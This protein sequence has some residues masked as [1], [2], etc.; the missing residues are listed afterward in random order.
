MNNRGNAYSMSTDRTS[1]LKKAVLSAPREISTLRAMVYTEIMSGKWNMPRL[2]SRARA[3]SLLMQNMPAVIYDGE[4]LVGGITEKRRGA[5]LAPETNT[6]GLSM[7]GIMNKPVKKILKTIT[8]NLVPLINRFSKKAGMALTNAGMLFDITFDNP[9][10]RGS[11]VFVVGK[12]EAADIKNTVLPYWKN[13]TAIK[14]FRASLGTEAKTE[15]NS[16]LYSAEHAF[17]GG[18]FLFHP[19]IER[20]AER[21]L[22]SV[23]HEAEEHYNRTGNPFYTS[24][25]VSCQGVIDRAEKYALQAEALAGKSI[26]EE[27]RQELLVIAEICRRVPA[28]PPVTFREGL[29]SLWFI[30]TAVANDDCGHEVPFGRWDQMLYPLYEKDISE[31]ILTREGALE[32]IECFILKTNEIEFLLHNGASFFED[33]NTGRLTLTIGG[34]DRDGKDATNEVSH[35]FIE[36]LSNARM[37]Q[38]NPAVRLHRDSPEKFV[39]LVTQMMAS[40]ANTVQIFNDETVIAGFTGNGYPPTD[41]RDY[42][43]TGCVQQMPFAAYG[44]ACAAHLVLPRTLEEFLGK[45]GDYKTYEEFYSA[46]TLYLSGII[47]NLTGV[48][49]AADRIHEEFLPNPF[50]SAIVDGPMQKGIDVK[51]GG[52]T[53][54]LTG[55]SLLGLGTVADSLMVIKKAVYTDRKYTLSALKR[56][57]VND[58]EGFESDRMFFVNKVAKY[59]N[60]EDEVDFI[61]RDVADFCASEAALYTTY[62]NG[63]FHIGVHSENGHVVFGF[64][65]GATPDGRSAMEPYSIGAGSARGREKSGYTASL[66]SVSKLNML[67]IVSGVSV[68]LRFNPSLF[69]TEEKVQRFTD[70]IQGYFFDY[71]GQ[72]LQATVVNAETLRLA[73]L[74]PLSYP[75]LL[76]RISGYSARFVELTKMTQDEIISRTEYTA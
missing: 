66:K 27:R 35:L 54:N 10:T 15:M 42:I 33:G 31:G 71:G 22:N 21:G 13:R 9:E 58:F 64:L 57:L 73:Q 67:K 61:A 3:F 52:S 62:R 55:I 17:G 76:V 28:N 75:D 1:M 23:I 34:M 51:S 16:H 12:S 8:S 69:D 2:E 49:G 32:L 4:L 36:A 11:H 50:I 18:V 63:K 74:D 68:N 56:M 70:M 24:L 37:I 44:S 48:L 39:R 47:K 41:A 29:Q 25:V 19:N 59:G 46:Y 53:H 20:T 72:N 65:T 40:G 60:D 14:K 6:E 7:G 5:F 45:K 38:P 43:I 26:T 30:Y